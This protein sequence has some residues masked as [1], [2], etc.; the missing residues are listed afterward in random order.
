MTFF[1]DISF[2][3]SICSISKRRNSVKYKTKTYVSLLQDAEKIGSDS[4]HF[5]FFFLI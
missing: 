3:D 4:R 1:G 5:Y 2:L